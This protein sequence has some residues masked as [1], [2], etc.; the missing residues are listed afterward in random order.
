MKAYRFRFEKLL[1]TKKI[2][3]DD[4]AAKTARARKILLMEEKKLQQIRERH[5][6]C[7]DRLAALQ[8]GEIDAYEIQRCHRYLQQLQQ[9]LN[10]QTALVKEIELRVEMLRKMLVETEKEKKLLEKLDEKEREAYIRDFLKIEQ[11][12]IDEVG[13]GKF[14]QRTAYQ[15]ARFPQQA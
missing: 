7:M 6:D 5:A 2:I 1:K 10:H 15:H 11:K 12:I 4:L 9:S 14:V 13:I 8:T 3:V